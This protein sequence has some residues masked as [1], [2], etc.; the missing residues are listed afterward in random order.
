MDDVKVR[1]V[2]RRPGGGVELERFFISIAV[3]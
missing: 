1:G 2:A 3:I